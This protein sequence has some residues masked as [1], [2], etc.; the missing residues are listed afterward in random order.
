MYRMRIILR[1]YLPVSLMLPVSLTLSASLLLAGCQYTKKQKL[2]PKVI[3]IEQ[4][5]TETII[6]ESTPLKEEQKPE[7]SKDLEKK[8]PI[9]KKKDKPEKPIEIAVIVSYFRFLN[10]LPEKALK[11]EHARTQKEFAADSSAI[12]RLRLAML[13]GFTNTKHRD[14]QRSLELL[15]RYLEDPKTLD[16]M[17]RDFSF[18][19]AS[20]VQKLKQQDKAYKIISHE[21]KKGRTENKKLKKMIEELKTIEKNLVERDTTEK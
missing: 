12:N 10:S 1:F 11:Q 4:V 3:P 18:L 14:T 6:Q 8:P 15:N 20:F 7:T 2:S 16:P 9:K 13:L 21:L 5:V 19:L 17:L